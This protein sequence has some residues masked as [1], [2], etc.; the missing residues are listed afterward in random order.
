M[1][2]PGYLTF[3]Q[4]HRM[5]IRQAQDIQAIPHNLNHCLVILVHQV[6]NVERPFPIKALR[7]FRPM[8]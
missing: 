4:L 3:H 1:F 6:R 5:V 2:L 8:P 7:W